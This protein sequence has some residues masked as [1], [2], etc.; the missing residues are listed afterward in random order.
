MEKKQNIQNKEFLHDLINNIIENFRS[1]RAVIV[2]L[3]K[4][5]YSIDFSKPVEIDTIN[6]LCDTLRLLVK[7]S[8]TLEKELE[9]IELELL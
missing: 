3:E 2:L 4:F 9:Y 8:N 1:I 6:N 7:N 5:L